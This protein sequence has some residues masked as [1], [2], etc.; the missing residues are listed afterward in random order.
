MKIAQVAPL[1]ESVPPLGYGG[2]ERVVS[3]LTEELV[4][5]GHDVTLFA[6]G[7][8]KTTARL[9]ATGVCALRL[10]GGGSDP[11]MSHARMLGKVARLASTFDVIHFHTDYLG[12]PLSRLLRTPHVTTLHG[13]L[14]MP[15]LAELYDEF[16]DVPVVS[17]SDN[18]REPLPA[19]NWQA[20]VYN[21]IPETLFSFHP[22]EGSY[23]VF[24]GRISP[25]KGV[26]E[27]IRIARTMGM[28]IRV[29]GKVDLADKA[30]FEERIRPLIGLPFV[31]FREEMNQA[32]KEAFLGGAYATLFPITWPEPFGL[33]MIESM[34]CGTPVIAYRQGSVPEVM[35]DGVSGYIV[36]DMAEAVRAVR[37]VGKLDRY[38][39]RKSFEERFSDTKMADGYVAVYET[40][41]AETGSP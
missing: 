12:F 38:K 7:D 23:L 35:Q 15:G 39:V 6:S 2:T 17:I 9:D 41:I 16:S 24:L 13:R 8:S 31:D 33:V 28:D 3:Y 26:E 21:G 22:A 11:Q 30:Y 37:K 36:N 20:T 19:A 18:H 34:A 10:G 25:E 27:A 29:S 40:L 14:D 32:E 5:R 1:I 4:R